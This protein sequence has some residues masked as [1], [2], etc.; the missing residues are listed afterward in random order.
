MKQLKCK[1]VVQRDFIQSPQLSAKIQRLSKASGAI[2]LYTA[3]WNVY[4]LLNLNSS[5]V[6]VITPYQSKLL[7]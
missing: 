4:K 3:V 1:H 5:P 6:N 7:L 2:C